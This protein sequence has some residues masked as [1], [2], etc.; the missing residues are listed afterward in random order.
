MGPFILSTQFLIDWQKNMYVIQVLIYNLKWLYVDHW[1]VFTLLFVINFFGEPYHQRLSCYYFNE[2][3]NLV[4][5]ESQTNYFADGY[6][7][8]GQ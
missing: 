8:H 5:W 7:N 4:S 6:G 1:E 3:C 2:F